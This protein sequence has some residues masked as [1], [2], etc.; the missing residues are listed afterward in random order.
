MMSDS[1]RLPV[2]PAFPFFPLSVALGWLLILLRSEH[3]SVP[4]DCCYEGL[5]TVSRRSRMQR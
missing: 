2:Q 3:A 5:S 4:R 1:L